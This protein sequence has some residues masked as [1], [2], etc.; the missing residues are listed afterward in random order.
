LEQAGQKIMYNLKEWMIEYPSEMELRQLYSES[1][2]WKEFKDRVVQ[3]TLAQAGT[4]RVKE[5]NKAEREL[6]IVERVRHA[7]Y[8]DHPLSCDVVLPFRKPV[9]LL[10]MSTGTDISAPEFGLSPR[11]GLYDY[12]EKDLTPRCK[13]KHVDPNL[14]NT[15]GYVSPKSKKSEG[16]A[17]PNSP[18]GGKKRNREIKII[19][20]GGSSMDLFS[21][22][23]RRD[24]IGKKSE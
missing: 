24:L 4:K 13:V 22:G 14:A 15:F 3:M 11:E 1:K 12:V 8:G 17:P 2:L 6:N 19:A 7:K 21:S 23:K 18:K 5:K 20:G 16:K 10:P 9:D